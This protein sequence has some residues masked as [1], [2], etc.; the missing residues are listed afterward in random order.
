MY[1]VTT[2]CSL[3]KSSV[4]TVTVKASKEEC[5]KYIEGYFNKF[6]GKSADLDAAIFFLN[7]KNS[8]D[9]SSYFY[10]DGNSFL[11]YDIVEAKEFY[12]QKGYKISYLEDKIENIKKKIEKIKNDMNSM[13]QA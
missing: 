2:V 4:E 7:K 3:D 8:E 13:G 12:K 1:F 6:Y 9:E 10:G 11:G 5:K